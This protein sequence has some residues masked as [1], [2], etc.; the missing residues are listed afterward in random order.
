MSAKLFSR[1]FA[2]GKVK[3]ASL[4]KASSSIS[5]RLKQRTAWYCARTISTQTCCTYLQTIPNYTQ[6]P[7]CMFKI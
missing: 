7:R 6:N 1:D 5:R 3:H 4:T 2:L